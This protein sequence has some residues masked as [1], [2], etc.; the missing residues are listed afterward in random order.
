MPETDPLSGLEHWGLMT[1][2]NHRPVVPTPPEAEPAGITSD[3]DV[4]HQLLI[5]SAGGE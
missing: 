2:Q 3:V 4:D 1:P 5:E